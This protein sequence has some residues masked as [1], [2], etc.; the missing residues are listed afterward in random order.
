MGTL[1]NPQQR[2]NRLASP[3]GLGVFHQ[4]TM[5]AITICSDFGAPKNKV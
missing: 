2:D 3:V 4:D 1:E 5:A